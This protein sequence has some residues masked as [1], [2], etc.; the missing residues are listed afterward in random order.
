MRH[1]MQTFLRNR[2]RALTPTTQV[3]PA[4]V[5]C[6]PMLQ[7]Q[8]PGGSLLW[9]QRA[10]SAPVKP[11]RI[12]TP[13]ALGRAFACKGAVL[14]ATSSALRTWSEFRTACDITNSPHDLLGRIFFAGAA[15][16]FLGTVPIFLSEDKRMKYLRQICDLISTGL[17]CVADADSLFGRLQLCESFLFG[18]ANRIYLIP[19]FRQKSSAFSDISPSLAKSLA[20]SHCFSSTPKSTTYRPNCVGGF[21]LVMFTDAS[22]HGLGVCV[23]SPDGRHMCASSHVPPTVSL[24]LPAG[25]SPIYVLEIWSVLFAARLPVSSCAQP[26]GSAFSKATSDTGVAAAAIH[27]TWLLLEEWGVLPWFERAMPLSTASESVFV[28]LMGGTCT[29]LRMSHPQ[30]PFPCPPGQARF[31]SLKSGQFC[32]R[33]ASL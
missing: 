11:G 8:P 7:K 27:H 6:P 13:S 24:S 5:G 19:L 15:P 29:R 3:S 14:N 21:G 16:D 18:R 30:F 12:F 9:H 1:D 2:A 23:C 20:W 31:T 4:G 26:V 32:L 28:V 33:L 10:A 25:A 22:L 17:R